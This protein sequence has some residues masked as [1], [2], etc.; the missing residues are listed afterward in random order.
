MANQKGGVG[1]TTTA[2]NLGAY[3]AKLGQNVLVVDLDPQANATSC[4]GVDKLKVT[5][6]TYET[7]L[8]SAPSPFILLNERLKLSLLPSSP[9][10]AGAEVELVEELARESKL[11][12]ALEPLDGRF[13]Y[14]LIDC[15]PSLGLLTVNGLVAAIN[16]VIVPVQ[17][18]YLALEGLGQL[19]ATIQRVRS[20]LFADLQV[21]GVVLT[22]FDPRTKLSADVVK[23]VKRHFPN[24]VFTSVIPRSVRLAEA[25]S[26]GLP[27]SEYAPSSMGAEAY[28][29]LARELLKGDGVLVPAAVA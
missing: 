10:L 26:Y 2:I 28:D 11:K 14:I 24:Q 12:K 16:G 6:G 19:T 13:D 20:A 18:E 1:K 3:L 22:M 7:L 21:R 15:P 9:A 5:G 8:G 23:E 25:P 17:C 29:A 27:I 4:L